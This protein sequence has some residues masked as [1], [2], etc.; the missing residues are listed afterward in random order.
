MRIFF[1]IFFVF[2]GYF[3]RW[4]AMKKLKNNFQLT[5]QVPTMIETGGIYRYMR[6]PAYFG[7]LIVI[8]GLCLIEPVLGIVAV[9]FVFFIARIVEEEKILNRYRE[10]QEYKKRTGMFYPKR[11]K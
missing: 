4:L 6:H 2:F 5:L 1:G 8:L 11:G 9:G 3:I 7:S 10:Y